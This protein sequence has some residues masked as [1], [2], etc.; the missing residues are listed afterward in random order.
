M[1]TALAFVVGA[2][3][4]V[5][6]FWC[7]GMDMPPERGATLL[8]VIGCSFVGGLGAAVAEAAP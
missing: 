4:V 2:L 8:V 7:G 5:G 1:R 3:L 6:L